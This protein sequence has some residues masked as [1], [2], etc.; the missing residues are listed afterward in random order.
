MGERTATKTSATRR[1]LIVDAEHGVLTALKFLVIGL[2]VSVAALQASADETWVSSV[3]SSREWAVFRCSNWLVTVAC[4]TD[5]DYA[6]AGSLPA[7]IAVGD[8]VTYTN[9]DGKSETFTVR[10][11]NYFVF[12]KDIDTV[13]GGQRIVTR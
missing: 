1:V 10:R 2:L 6:A 4:G 8:S 13:W 3:T 9:R 5:K 12:D 11:I 7:S